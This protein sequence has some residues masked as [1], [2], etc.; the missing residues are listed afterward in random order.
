MKCK[1]P[2]GL[3]IPTYDQDLSHKLKK[4]NTSKKIW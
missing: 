2:R 1:P 4:G 3:M